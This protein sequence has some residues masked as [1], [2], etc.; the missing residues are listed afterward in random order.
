MNPNEIQLIA[1][2]LDGTL[3]HEDKSISGYTLDVIRRL[4][5]RNI[6]IVPTTGRNIAGL[7]DNILNVQSIR[8]AICSNGANILDAGTGELLHGCALSRKSALDTLD[9]LR[10]YP[11]FIY[12][13]TSQGTVRSSD[14]ETGGLAQRYPYVQFHENNVPDIGAFLSDP[15]ITLWKIGV[16]TYDD[17]TFRTLLEAGIPSPDMTLLRTGE[18][19]LEIN[20]SEASKGNALR[21]LAEML[22]IPM[23]RVMA[24]G[25]NQNDISMLKEAGVSVAMGNAQED[26]KAAADHVALTNEEDG[27]A[28]FLAGCFGL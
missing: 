14:W 7:K 15:S 3:L 11:T 18:C 26:V 23:S 2:D 25:D 24:I 10:Q 4:A 1:L 28:V 9:Y 27:A 5:D 19:N 16:F 13:H 22:G 12:V 17:E 6:I 20:S 21:T 8:Y